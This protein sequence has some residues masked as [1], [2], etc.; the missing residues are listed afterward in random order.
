MEMHNKNLNELTIVESLTLLKEGKISSVELTKA[1]LDQIDK[2]DNKIKAYI[3][4]TR[5]LA[6]EQAQTADAQ[7][8][9]LGINAWDSQPLLG[10]PYSCKDNFSTKGIETTASS[11]ILKG[12][13]PPYESTVTQ[14]LKDAGAILLGKTNM[15]AFAHGSSTE[16]S[17]FFTTKNPWNVSTTPGGS[18]GGTAAAVAANMCIFGIGSETAGSIRGPAAWCGITGLKPSYGRV[19][20]YGVIAMA[21]S[22]DSPGPLAKTAQDCALIAN[23]IAGKDNL[24]ATTADSPVENYLHSTDHYSLKTLKIGIPKQ[25]INIELEDGVRTKIED[26]IAFL[27]D[28]GVT[29]KELD[30]LDTKYSIAVYTILQRSEVSSNLARLDGIRYGQTRDSF[31][32]EA[33]NRMMLGAYTLSAGYYDAYYAKA[34]KV[35]T[36][37]IED[38]AKAFKEVDLILAPTMPNLAP[39]VGISE[40][41]PLFG[42]LADVLQEPSSI[43]GLP[44]VAVPCGTY[45]GLPVSIQFIG[46]RLSEELVLAA[47]I[48]YQKINTHHLNFP[49]L[50]RTTNV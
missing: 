6:L 32:T 11:N 3:T 28:Y 10:I 12:Y 18:S 22:T 40:S 20:R 1:C 27:K 7:I 21:S 23:I 29:F 42:E 49:D 34:Q 47:G 8:Q 5:D 44:A 38:F 25:Y 43:A 15:D 41:S 4:V 45:N 9:Q 37:I 39:K 31:G 19:S 24:D 16:T 46:P 13:I 26:T 35:R 30:M 36:L 17:D 14:K 2:Y 50:E 48:E 33:R